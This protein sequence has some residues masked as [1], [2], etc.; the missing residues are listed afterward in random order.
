MARFLTIGMMQMPVFSTS[1]ENFHSI[2]AQVKLLMRRNPR[3]DLIVGVEGGIGFRT[4]DRIPGPLTEPYS[5]LAKE[6]GIYLIPGTLFETSDD[7]AEGFHYNSAPIFGPDGELID[8]Y[9]KMAP[10]L[11]VEFKTTPGQRYVVFTIP[12]KNIR[13]GVMIC[14]DLNFPEIA[15]NLTLQGAEVLI[16]LTE[17]LEEAY[18]INRPLHQARA[19]ENQAFLVSVNAVGQAEGCSMYGHSCAIDPAGRFLLEAGREEALLSITLDVD[20]VKRAREYGTNFSDHYLKHLR[21]LDLPS[22][23]AGNMKEAPVFL[24]LDTGPSHPKVYRQSLEESHIG[25]K[26]PKIRK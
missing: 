21:D 14:Y 1:S 4:C 23:F 7:C 24:N 19:I 11:P 25:S 8:V 6:Y 3:P 20:E 9:R 12:E 5:R 15:R 16:K 26:T 13:V 22:P 17:D 18:A 10:W 2:E